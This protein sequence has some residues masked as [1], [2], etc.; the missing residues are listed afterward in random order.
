MCATAWLLT[1]ASLASWTTGADGSARE[2]KEQRA[3]LNELAAQLGEPK[4]ERRRA[5]V[6][7]LADMGTEPAW[8]L[9][10]AALA[11]PRAEVADEAQWQLGR[12]EHP[13]LRKA[14]FGSDGLGSR[15]PW[16]RLRVAEA[17][18][19]MPLEL[20]AND[21]LPVGTRGDLAVSRTLL[22]SLERRAQAG[23]LGEPPLGLARKVEKLVRGNADD[24]LR[25]DALASLAALD[26]DAARPYVE[27]FAEER[28][29][30]C[31]TAALVLG[32]DLLEPDAALDLARRCAA[33]EDDAV[34]A[35]AVIALEDLG[36]REGL[37]CLVDR[38]ESE[39]RQRTRQR[40]LDALQRLSGLKHRADPRPWRAWIASLP[41]DWRPARGELG[42]A[43]GGTVAF[44]GLPLLSDRLAFLIDFSGS[45]WVEREGRGTRKTAVD[46]ALC[47][48]LPKLDES[49]RFM[50][51]PYTAE[52]HPWR[53]ELEYA[54]PRTV[55]SAL[56]DFT[57]CRERGSGNAYAAIELALAQP[58]VDTIVL[59]TDGAPTGGRRWKLDLIAAL[60]AFELR[61][62][63]VAI[64]LV[65]VDAPSGLARRWK[66]IAANSGGRVVEVSL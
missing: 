24:A 48:A 32:T 45:L 14:L 62:R 42:P 31:R 40:A 25:C 66:E 58:D 3:A 64:D 23:R 36:L 59:L 26:P 38:L 7:A 27:R 56:K 21:L 10:L 60:L 20:D 8:E 50:L 11:D 37:A 34:R 43:T 19:R 29:P 12:L 22:W 57:D 35:A 47:A 16:V 54:K 41:P 51:V 55:Q 4:H 61:F 33:D 5:A 28:A 9:L 17:F 46:A 44:A 39:P 52:P 49:A 18:G 13:A 2:R 63:P 30:R 53:D 6:R 15:D 1:I 65:L